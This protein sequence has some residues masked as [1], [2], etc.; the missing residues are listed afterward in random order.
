VPVV[1]ITIGRELGSVM[2]KTWMSGITIIAFVSVVTFLVPL[3]PARALGRGKRELGLRLGSRRLEL[4][5]T[6]LDGRSLFL[7]S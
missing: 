6:K 1:E 2:L 3:A 4:D 7:S 5:H